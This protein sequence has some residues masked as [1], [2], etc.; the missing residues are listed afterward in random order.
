MA[1]KIAPTNAGNDALVEA[2]EGL[3]P[4]FSIEAKVNEYTIEKGVMVVASAVMEAVAHVTHQHSRMPQILEVAASE[5]EETPE[6]TEAEIPAE[7]NH[8]RTQWKRKQ[9]HKLQMK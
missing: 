2:A 3:R 9:P 1:F 5:S 4:A 6:T 7:E 8:R